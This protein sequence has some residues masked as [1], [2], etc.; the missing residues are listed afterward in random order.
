MPVDLL[1]EYE[2][3]VATPPVD[4]L[5][6]YEAPSTQGQVHLLSQYEAPGSAGSPAPESPSILAQVLQLPK[7]VREQGAETGLTTAGGFEASRAKALRG[8]AK[9]PVGLEGRLIGQAGVPRT[10]EARLANAIDRSNALS[11]KRADESAQDFLQAASAAPE[12]Y[13]LD[14]KLET[15][16]V[17]QA[18]RGLTKGAGM[19][20]V[21]SATGIPGL[22]I[23]GSTEAFGAAKAHGKSDDEA[24]EE[25]TRALIGLAIFG[26]ANKAVS[27]GIA[28]YLGNASKLRTFLVQTL[29]QTAGNEATSR[30]ISAYEAALDAEP[31]K[32]QDA[33]VA[34]LSKMDVQSIAQNVGFALMGGF[35]AA[36]NRSV[37]ERNELQL[38][39]V[40]AENVR[41]EQAERERVE[42]V[43]AEQNTEASRLGGQRVAQGAEFVKPSEEALTPEQRARAEA[44]QPIV[45]GATVPSPPQQGQKKEEAG[46]LDLETGTVRDPDGTIHV[47][48][49]TGLTEVV[50][51]SPKDVSM[52]VLGTKEPE[53]G[54]PSA[55]QIEEANAQVL[56][57]E[58]A[59]PS[60]GV[61]LREVGA[62]NA[63]AEAPPAEAQPEKVGPRI[64]ATG[65][66]TPEGIARG[67][68]WNTK[69]ADIIKSSEKVKLAL[70]EGMTIDQLDANKGFIVEEN[71]K[72]RFAGRKEALEIARKS[73]QVDES[74]LYDPEKQGLIS[75]ALIEAKAP[76]QATSEPPK[77]PEA[78]PA[79][80]PEDRGRP[81]IPTPTGPRNAITES[82]RFLQ[83]LGPRAEP[84]R[85]TAPE[86]LAR[87]QE[88][89]DSEPNLG[90]RLITELNKEARAL[91][92]EETA[93]VTR[94][95]VARE[96]E[97]NAALEAINGA[98]NETARRD[99]ENRLSAARDANQEAY[100]ALERAGTPTGQALAFRKLMMNRDYSLA[101]M[102][103]EVRAL[104]GGTP[105]AAKDLAEVKALH[106]RIKLAEDRAAA[107]EEKLAQRT[108]E[109]EFSKLLKG[110]RQEASAARK[111]GKSILD[112]IISNGEAAQ[113][114]LR[115]MRAEGQLLS[116]ITI[117]NPVEFGLQVQI[118][119]GYLAK[120]IKTLAEFTS[121]LV[122]DFGAE[123]EPQAASIFDASRKY[124][125]EA[126]SA[127]PK[128]RTIEEAAARDKTGEA[129]NPDAVYDVARAH[130]NA[131]VEGFDAVM[132]ATAKTLEA[133]HPG[134]TAREVRDAFSG[135]GK[136][137]RPSQ[138]A[139]RVKLREYRRLGQLASAIED[140]QKKIAPMKSGPQRDKATEAVRSKMAELK[141]VM[142][143]NGIQVTS[144]EQ[145]LA[146]A[147]KAVT[148]RLQ[149]SIESLERQ[150]AMKTRDLPAARKGAE[151]PEIT[152]LRDRVSEL[153][154][155]LDEVAPKAEETP[156]QRDA[157]SIKAVQK[158]IAE[159]DRQIREGGIPRRT[160]V[161]PSVA[162]EALRSERD[163]MR[164]LLK[165]IRD[166]T[167]TKRSPE[168]IALSRYKKT[169]ET[170][171]RALQERM[172]KGDYEKKPKKETELDKE[173]LDARFQ[174]QKAK[175]A[176]EQKV[177]EYDLSRRSK[178]QK[179]YDTALE[180][181]NTSRA[182]MT[183]ADV[184]APLR[185]GA[186]IT[187]AHPL[188]SLKSFPEMFK[189]F[190]SEK[191]AFRVQESLSDPAQRPNAALYRQ[192][193]LDLTETGT[194]GITRRK[195]EEAYQ[196]RFARKIPIVAGSERAYSTFLNL[197]RADSFDAMVKNL[198]KGGKVTDAEA[199]AIA[200]FVNVATGRGK[201]GQKAEQATQFLNSIFFAPKYAWSRFQLIGGQ[202]FYGGN[203]RT[204][205]AIAKEYARFLIGAGVVVGLAQLAGGKVEEDPRSSEFAKLRFGNTRVDM[206]GGLT[207]VTTLL[208]RLGTGKTITAKGKEMPLRIAEGQ[209]KKFGQRTV[210]DLLTRF[211]RQKLSPPVSA[212]VDIAS[213]E[214]VVGERVTPAA[215]LKER[216]TPLS[217][218]DIYDAMKEQ[219]VAKGT[220]FGLLSLLGAGTSTYEV[221]GSRK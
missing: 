82:N 131:G 200:N 98:T 126:V 79:A 103:A 108:G 196:S 8:E 184:S 214:N 110:A 148:T 181:L 20:A 192:A 50:P 194:T 34:A 52:T 69:H 51:G 78:P 177:F 135:Y 26:G 191:A 1:S 17:T 217:F 21:A 144:P 187:L 3:P 145:Q 49:E 155:T 216:V 56:R 141:R 156:E 168:E 99:A 140:A 218:G 124:F 61:G 85:R 35:E 16:L 137:T 25:A 36:K 89:I 185:Q 33:A 105:L 47:I 219:G 161:E 10:A 123:I 211:L 104:K 201:Y 94:E 76:E 4:L 134:I 72:E 9:S 190:A 182:I 107:A 58:S 159:L 43:V 202:P 115:K 180:V 18:A 71:G 113:E 40:A 37:A 195:M 73:G 83:G 199:K 54:A 154:Q 77:P 30:S 60:E 125:D 48:D 172:A 38:P 146:N 136:V 176:Y 129:L 205:R 139:D 14:P 66:L 96:N 92:P 42:K 12:E 67:E 74:V 166:A 13:G 173:A 45:G 165:E 143:E 114:K 142:E 95:K 212:I 62:R 23:V 90:S 68:G 70:A 163:S 122:K 179:V 215:V 157:R 158:S 171:T 120:G 164:S 24:D 41:R 209:K 57:P 132:N 175:D 153:R 207:Q 117:V 213:G 6:E 206:F 170:R 197:L 133:N 32:R 46:R 189:A 88:L 64:V 183:S 65:I 193:G 121:R 86:V 5:S 7:L 221:G 80:A 55:V 151:T 28:K 130:V 63:L 22:A 204:R 174:Y 106:D 31:G 127:G 150:I 15:G 44:A 162:L 75:E 203:A 138:A 81:P 128:I 29:G 100:S 188:R 19:F 53:K 102:E 119:A 186:F 87:A 39:E 59:G 27:A 111:E 149:N 11:A 109:K 112:R 91:L 169:L 147:E 2:A 97:Y 178:A 101:G 93:V 167:K 220:A 84:L 208:A 118:G 160:S 116:S 210:P 198:G 152:Q